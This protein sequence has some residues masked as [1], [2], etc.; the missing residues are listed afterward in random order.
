[1]RKTSALISEWERRTYAKSSGANDS[2]PDG[3]ASDENK[4]DMDSSVST[5]GSFDCVAF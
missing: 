5:G 4:A 1:M 2:S 3:C